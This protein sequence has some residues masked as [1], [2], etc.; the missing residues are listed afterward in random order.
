MILEVCNMLSMLWRLVALNPARAIAGIVLASALAW[1]S[2]QSHR[3]HSRQSQNAVTT[4]PS[5]PYT[6]PAPLHRRA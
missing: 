2:V 3:L 1:G 4:P 5:R 6:S